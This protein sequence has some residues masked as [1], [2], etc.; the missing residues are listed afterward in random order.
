MLRGVPGSPRSRRAFAAAWLAGGAFA[1][2]CSLGLDPA[3]ISSRSDGGASAMPDGGGSTASATSSGSTQSSPGL[4][5]C[6]NDAD[7][8]RLAGAGSCVGAASCD[9]TWHVCMFDVCNTGSCEVASCDLLAKQCG[10][11]SPYGFAVSVFHI[12]SG[13]GG[14]WGPASAVAAAYPFLFVLTTNGV[15]AFNVANPMGSVPPS[16]TI[17]GAPFIP[18]AL[19]TAGRRVYLV[20]PVEG[21]G[22]TYRQAIAWIDAPGDP[23]LT[24]LNATTAWIGTTEPSLASA[25]WNGS[26]GVAL[27]YGATADPTS[28]VP[29]APDDST[30]LVPSPIA[31]LSPGAAIVAASGSELLAYR[32]GASSRHPAFS[33]VS[34]VAQNSG[35]ASAEQVIGAYGPVDDQASFASGGD[36]TVL[37]TSAPVRVVDGGIAG[38]SSARVTWLTRVTDGGPDAAPLS[39]AIHADLE[40]YPASTTGAVVGPS[41]YVD[42]NDAIVLAASSQDPESTSVQ[43]FSRV[44]GALASGQRAVIPAPPSSVGL[45]ASRGFAYLLVQD[46]PNNLSATVYIVAPGCPGP[47]AVT[48]PDGGPTPEGGVLPDGGVLGSDAGKGGKG[49]G[50][51]HELN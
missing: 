30:T 6:A 34:G 49:Q 43:L 14:G 23:F 4:A 3:L 13:V 50:T 2:G 19:V 38:I 46:D 48:E 1:A 44:T 32:Y 36:S 22:P 7:C 12:A 35:Q 45:A 33:L 18:A 15:A 17:H 26:T 40:T 27:T 11:P 39:T 51:F 20:S 24:S 8:A 10:A 42:S 16:V 28:N 31:A 37:W 47:A 25:I 41:A 29:S 21:G 5:T 9:P